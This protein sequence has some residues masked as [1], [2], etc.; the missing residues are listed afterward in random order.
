MTQ[1]TKNILFETEMFL[2]V[3]KKHYKNYFT[4]ILVRVDEVTDDAVERRTLRDVY[5][6]IAEAGLSMSSLYEIVHNNL[7]MDKE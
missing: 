1:K 7:N 3:L 6:K 2:H 5:E 4:N